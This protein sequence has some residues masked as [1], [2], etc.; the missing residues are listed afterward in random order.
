MRV[1]RVNVLRL[2]F[3][4]ALT[5]ACGC[6]SPESF[7]KNSDAGL[8]LGNIDAPSTGGTGAAGDTGGATGT[9]GTNGAGGF[10]AGGVVGTG[11]TGTGGMQ[12]GG[13]AAGSGGSASG[14]SGSGGSGAGGLG[15]RGSGGAST[16]GSAGGGAGGLG[17]AGGRGGAGGT[18]N[19][20]CMT[21]C[22]NP[23]VITVQQYSSGMLGV[24]ATCHETTVNIGGGNCT[25]FPPPR[26]FSING[27]PV[28]C[29]GNWTLPAKILGGYCFQASAGTPTFSAFI[30]F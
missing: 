10:G 16:G 8:V 17:A 13:N 9:G 28:S 19:G 22:T 12:T 15:G 26:T 23:V 7:H 5:V 30:T 20:P 2:S 21:Y 24:G 1:G 18:N 25:S 14:G 4:I 27:T 6:Q 3:K 29:M 11:G